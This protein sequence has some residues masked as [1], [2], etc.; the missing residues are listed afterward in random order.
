MNISAAK[1]M[2]VFA[3]L[4]LFMVAIMETDAS[5]RLG[6]G[7]SFGSRGTRSYSRPATTYS[8]PA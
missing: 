1:G 5:A 2:A 4:I 3:A 8:R 7:R 6:G